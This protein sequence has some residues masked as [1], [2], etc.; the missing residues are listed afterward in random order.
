MLEAR[1]EVEHEILWEMNRGSTN[2]WHENWTG[3]GALYHVLPLEFHINK[4]LQEVAE[5]RDEEGWNDQLLDQTF[6]EDIAEHLRK[7]VHFDH[8]DD[9]WDTPRW[10]PTP[11]G[12]FSVSSAWNILRYRDTIKPYFKLMWTKG[13]PFKI[14]FFIW[15]LWQSKLSTDDLWRRNGYIIVSRCWCFQNPVEETL[16]HIFLTSSTSNRV[17]KIFLQAAGFIVNLVQVHQVIKSW[18]SSR[19]CA[20]LRPLFQ[21]VPAIITWEL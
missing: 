5:L 4:E 17:W 6:P 13:L 19:C 1:E 7:E 21:A 2:V 18:W 11:S 15:R 10:M 14:S 3:V 16:Q 12:K 8:T 9:Y 20:K